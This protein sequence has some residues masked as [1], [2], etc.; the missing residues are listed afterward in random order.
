MILYLLTF[1]I[2]FLAFNFLLLFK[3]IQVF[4]LLVEPGQI[5]Y[6][7]EGRKIEIPQ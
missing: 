5:R 7:F 2:F 6:Q 3:F 4:R 1:R